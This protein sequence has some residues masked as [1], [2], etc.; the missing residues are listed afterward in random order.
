MQIDKL[1]EKYNQL[2]KEGEIEINSLE[3]EIGVLNIELLKVRK[4][5]KT[6]QQ[7]DDT[8]TKLLSSICYETKA[9]LENLNQKGSHIIHLSNTCRKFETER[10]KVSVYLPLDCSELE[11]ELVT[12][13][14]PFGRQEGIQQYKGF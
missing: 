5:L 14:V 6:E 10:E 11:E 13:G 2:L 4:T 12:E 3:L 8:K 9:F 7:N 1:T